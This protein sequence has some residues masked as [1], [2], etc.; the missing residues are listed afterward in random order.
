MSDEKHFSSTDVLLGW[1]LGLLLNGLALLLWA[2]FAR[3]IA[4]HLPEML[5]SIFLFSIG[6]IGVIQLFYVLPAI[7][8][9]RRKQRPGIVVGLII[10]AS[11]TALLNVACWTDPSME[12]FFLELIL[13]M[14]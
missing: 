10:A 11:L 4:Q 7:R 5:L 3:T 8:I 9:A 14:H 13:G 2:V 6:L 12:R 1:I